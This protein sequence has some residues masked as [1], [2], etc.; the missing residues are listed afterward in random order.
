M[1]TISLLLLLSAALI[2]HG[3]RSKPA[4]Q[5]LT[6]PSQS[7]SPHLHASA[8]PA[9]HET[10]T[11]MRFHGAVD[12]HRLLQIIEADPTSEAAFA[13]MQTLGLAGQ[14]AEPILMAALAKAR[15]I[16]HLKA[17]ACA[18]AMHG[19]EDAVEAIWKASHTLP[20]AEMRRALLTAFDHVTTA[21]GIQLIASALVAS[22]EPEVLEAATRTLARASDAETV[23]FLAELAASATPAQQRQLTTALQTLATPASV[24]ALATLAAREDQ[25]ALASAAAIGLAKSGS[26]VASLALTQAFEATTEKGPSAATH[27]QALVDIFAGTRVTADNQAFLQIQAAQSPSTAWREAARTALN[28]AHKSSLQVGLNHRQR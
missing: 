24:P 9:S 17:L 16:H 2:W 1:K 5:A 14:T 11:T 18:L 13:A 12:L 26:A 25:P 28:S 22:R 27:R 7:L 19:S 6:T 8:A 10:Q 4:H 3:S 20:D 15:D 23:A 21:K